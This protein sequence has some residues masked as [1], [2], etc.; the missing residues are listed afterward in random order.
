MQVTVT[1]SA[2][3]FVIMNG[4]GVTMRICARRRCFDSFETTLL[5]FAWAA[6]G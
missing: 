4:G 1:S 6:G 5:Q 2:N 3:T